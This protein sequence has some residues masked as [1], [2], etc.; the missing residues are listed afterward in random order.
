MPQPPKLERSRALVRI[1]QPVPL[2]MDHR[3]VGPISD[4]NIDNPTKYCQVTLSSRVNPPSP[5][6]SKNSSVYGQENITRCHQNDILL[7]V[8]VHTLN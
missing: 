1:L 6:I 2:D 3:F 8:K 5:L 7:Q 4:V